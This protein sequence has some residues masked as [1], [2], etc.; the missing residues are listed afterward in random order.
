MPLV[1]P[2]PLEVL[3]VLVLVL[4]LPFYL[5]LRLSVFR[6]VKVVRVACHF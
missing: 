3:L 6:V 5:S 1:P 2:L 4:L